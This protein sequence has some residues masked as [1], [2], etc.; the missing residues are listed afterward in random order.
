MH[1]VKL[2]DDAL[3]VIQSIVEHHVEI[4][5]LQLIAHTV[6]LNWR[7]RYATS[8]LQL[9]NLESAFY[10]DKPLQRLNYQ[11]EEFRNLSLDNLPEVESHVVWS[12]TSKVLC[13]DAQF[14]HIPMMN[15]HPTFGSLLDII[16]AIRLVCGTEP[17]FLLASGRYFHY[18]GNFLLNERE[19]EKF[20]ASFLMPCCLVSP[21]YIG[22]R[23]LAGECTLRLTTNAM[24][25]PVIPR[26]VFAF[27]GGSKWTKL[28]EA[29]FVLH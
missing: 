4:V 6:G 19:W 10:Q 7:Q 14:R 1:T 22:N 21:R 20:L 12:M 29:P 15:F 13:S 9:S 2:N 28:S 5:S 18:Y 26:V 3:I 17:G 16:K 27:D 23:L 11:R 8:K 24:Y 25:K